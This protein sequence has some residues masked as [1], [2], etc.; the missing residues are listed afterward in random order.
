MR[1][2]LDESLATMP[3]TEG[4]RGGLIAP[5]AEIEICPGL[6]AAAV[7]PD[8]AAL[9]AA[10]DYG[11]V[12]D[13]HRLLPQLAVVFEKAGPVMMRTPVRPDEIEQSPIRLIDAGSSAELLA[14]ATINSFFGIVPEGFLREGES[15]AQV[16][17]VEGVLALTPPEA[18]FN[19]DL[20]RAWFILTSEPYVSH[21]LVIPAGAPEAE[22]DQLETAARAI[23]T[24][25]VELRREIR[26]RVADATGL[27]R[28]LL[29]PLFQA[30]R[31]ALTEHDRRALLMLLQLGNRSG[32]A[33]P[34]VSALQFAGEE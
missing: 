4:V 24:A 32:E 20:A 34:Y 11:K 3:I 14:R 17:V 13:T 1:L 31:W 30:T 9:I 15:N 10:G 23:S 6:T 28:D 22:R 5:A 12:Q 29:T 26:K 33:G 25:T 2:L 7:G 27:D 19:E 18:G 8:D 16:A 21:L